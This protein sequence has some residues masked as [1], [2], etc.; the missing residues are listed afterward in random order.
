MN[1]DESTKTKKEPATLYAQETMSW[2]DALSMGK[3][4]ARQ[5]V[6]KW[7]QLKYFPNDWIREK[8]R[9]SI[10]YTYIVNK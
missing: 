4:P 5:D 8:L 2:D 1:E 9:W 7:T 10:H 3:G 6:Y